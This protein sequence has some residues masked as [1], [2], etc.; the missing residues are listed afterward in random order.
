VSMHCTSMNQVSFQSDW[1]LTVI[2]MRN[3]MVFELDQFFVFVS[4]AGKEIALSVQLAT[5]VTSA[6]M[7]FLHM[8][9]ITDLNHYLI[10]P[11]VWLAFPC[12]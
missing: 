7:D 6:M 2:I 3:F 4:V 8:C 10:N 5:T 1:S 11:K 12:A 9:I